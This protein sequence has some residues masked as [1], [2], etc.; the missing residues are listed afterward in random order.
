[1]ETTHPVVKSKINEI[2]H[3][4]N[5]LPLK[6]KDARLKMVKKLF[7]ETFTTDKDLAYEEKKEE[8]ESSDDEASWHN[9]PKDNGRHICGDDLDELPGVVPLVRQTTKSIGIE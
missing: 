9:P 3:F 2:M 5:N 4:V 1:M 8:P 7:D 6:N